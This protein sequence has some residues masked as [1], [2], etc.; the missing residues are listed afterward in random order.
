MAIYNA[1]LMVKDFYSTND[2]TISSNFMT[3]A[4]LPY[5]STKHLTKQINPF[6]QSIITNNYKNGELKLII[7]NE[8]QPNRQLENR[9]NFTKYYTVKGNIFDKNNWKLNTLQK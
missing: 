7:L 2:F 4:D 5:L 1:L 8:W 3:V 6:T 9:F